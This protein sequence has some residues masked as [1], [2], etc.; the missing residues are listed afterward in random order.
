MA[1]LGQPYLKA[2]SRRIDLPDVAQRVALVPNQNSLAVAHGFASVVSI[3]DT[4]T[5]ECRARFGRANGSKWMETFV[6]V[7]SKGQYIALPSFDGQ[8]VS[9]YSVTEPD[10]IESEVRA[11]GGR[12]TSAE[13]H[14]D[15]KRLIMASWDGTVRCWRADSG[16]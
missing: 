12:I 6:A 11:Q 7:S 10:R 5:G 16:Q 13:F 1:N 15:G 8:A 14:P 3:W 9:L 4:S 2:K